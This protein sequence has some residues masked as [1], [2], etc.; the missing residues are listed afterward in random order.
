MN[1]HTYSHPPTHTHFLTNLQTKFAQARNRALRRN[2]TLPDKEPK[3]KCSF[4]SRGHL[5]PTRLWQPREEHSLVFTLVFTLSQQGRDYKT[6]MS[7][8]DKL[9]GQHEVRMKEDCKSVK[10]VSRRLFT[11]L[12][13]VL[14]FLQYYGAGLVKH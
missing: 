9:K 10:S 2:P 3:N 5:I 13:A 14:T 6:N 11:H 8:K 7:V 4:Y 1:T 12:I